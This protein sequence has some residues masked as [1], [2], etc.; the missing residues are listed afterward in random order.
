MKTSLDELFGGLARGQVGAA[1]RLISLLEQGD[2][3][4]VDR[5]MERVYPQTGHSWVVG[6]TGPP[7]AGKSSLVSQL[8]ARARADGRSVGVILVDPSSP[9]SGGAVLGDRIRMSAFSRDDQVFLRS[10]GSRGR[11]GGLAMA[12][13]GAVRVLDCLRKDFVFVETVGA[14]QVDVDVCDIADTVC[15]VLMPGTGDAIQSLKAGIMEVNDIFV[16]NKCDRPGAEEA[17]NHIQSVLDITAA[18]PGRDFAWSVP[19]F[20][21]NALLGEGAAELWERIKSHRELSRV[22]DFRRRRKLEQAKKETIE[23]IMR[24]LEKFFR[25]QVDHKIQVSHIIEDLASKAV[26][27]QRASEEVFAA[28]AK[29]AWTLT[30]LSEGRGAE[31]ER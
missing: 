3:H 26:S 19:I 11:L 4:Q 9:V 12:T 18:Q 21:T 23:I 27:P 10:M 8:I 17:A 30:E 25:R 2:D 7:G 28:I 20:L 22:S 6:I 5:I 15:L 14:G 29:S 1:S 31:R 13:L 16:V 24:K